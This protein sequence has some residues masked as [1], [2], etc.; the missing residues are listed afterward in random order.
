M[1]VRCLALLGSGL[2]GQLAIALLQRQGIEVIAA[3]LNTVFTTQATAVRQ[4]AERLKIPLVT[5]L[6]DAEYFQRVRHPRF[7]YARELAPCLDCRVHMLRAAKRLLEEHHANFLVTGDV[8]GQ[9]MP[10]QSKR[11]LAL[12]D[13]HAGVEGHVLRPL[14]AKLL[15]AT[16]FEQRQDVDRQ[17]L[18]GVQGR[19]RVEQHRLT[20]EL[21]W[22]NPPAVTSG[23]LLA[24]A[25]FAHRTQDLLQH[26]PTATE[27][28]F[29]LLRLGR[30]YRIDARTKAIVGRSGDENSEL[31]EWYDRHGDAGDTLLAP[32][33]FVG[34]TVLVLGA[35]DE[36][37]LLFASKLLWK[38][39]R[40]VAQSPEQVAIRRKTGCADEVVAMFAADLA[41]LDERQIARL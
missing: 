12:V 31:V 2:D 14:S 29:A 24:D 23:C 40:V 17:R 22:G 39:R 37:H 11:D 4:A 33:D 25:A 30:H 36:S 15:E 38:H 18:M 13:F 28:H 26:A 6:A 27:E 5:I 9:R 7:G 41:A 3:T 32:H 19:G 20:R 21:G 10:G 16:E 35:N 34:P 1:P 8:V